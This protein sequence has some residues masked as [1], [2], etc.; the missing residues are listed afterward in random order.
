MNNSNNFF[1]LVAEFQK[2]IDWLNQVLKGG[3]GDSVNID[4]EVKPSISKSIADHWNEIK[5]MLDGRIAFE[6]RQALIDSGAPPAGVVL[7]NVWNDPTPDY[8]GLYGWTGTNWQKSPYDNWDIAMSIIST[9]Q[10]NTFGVDQRMTNGGYAIVEDEAGNVPLGITKEGDVLVAG[11]EAK[12]W[13][14]RKEASG[15]GI[16]YAI[17]DAVGKVALAL[18]GDGTAFVPE[19]ETLGFKTKELGGYYNAIYVITDEND[20]VCFYID[21]QGKT[22]TFDPDGYDENRINKYPPTKEPDRGELNHFLM[23]GQSLSVGSGISG[24][25]YKDHVYTFSGGHSVDESEPGNTFVET[26]RHYMPAGIQQAAMQQLRFLIEKDEGFDPDKK[27]YDIVTSDHGLGGAWIEGLVKGTEPYEK[28]MFQVDETLR[29]ASRKCAVVAGTSWIQ[30][31]GNYR[32]TED[33]YLA[34]FLAFLDDYQTDLQA[35]TGQLTKPPMFTY[36]MATSHRGDGIPHTAMA[37][38]MASEQRDNVYLVTP[39]YWQHHPDGIHMDGDGYTHVGLN[40]GKVVYRVAFRGE[41]WKP[42]SPKQVWKPNNKTVMVRFHVP[43][44]PLAFDTVNVSDP[45]NYGFDVRDDNGV[46]NIVDVQLVGN[47]QVRITVDRDIATN[48]FVSYAYHW[49]AET[50]AG[51][52]NGPRGCLRDSDSTQSLLGENYPLYNWCIIFNEA[53]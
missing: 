32:D 25:K 42:L 27:N 40:W 4:G 29:L 44:P 5:A 11:L 47:D 43:E 39:F 52:D 15:I 36:Q 1:Q 10:R 41:D 45:G 6:T 31:E 53:I 48:P 13:Q 46:L 12:A 9:L 19:L 50:V 26:T 51:K 49:A 2:N 33:V 17:L 16:G 34:K 23:Y 37:L 24:I 22:H 8:N 35:K 30:G 14:Q 38:K 3:E 28:G 21:K 18:K 20:Q 7:A